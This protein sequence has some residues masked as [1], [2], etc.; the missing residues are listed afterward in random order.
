MNTLN[1]TYNAL[2]ENEEEINYK[3]YIKSLLQ[4]NVSNVL[5]SRLPRRRKP[6]NIHS[7]QLNKKLVNDHS[8]KADDFAAIF[9]VAKILRKDIMNLRRWKFNGSFNDFKIPKSLTT[10][11]KW[12]LV[13]PSPSFTNESAKKTTTKHNIKNIAQIIMRSTKST[14]QITQNT[15][16]PYKDTVKTPFAVGLGILVHKE[17]RNKKMIEYLSDLGLSISYKKVMKLE[18]GLGNMIVEKRNS[19]EGV[20]IPDNLTQNSCLHF[21]FDNIDFENY[22]ENGKCK[23]HGTTTVIFQ[24]KQNQ[25]EKSIEITL[26]NDLAFHDTTD[27]IHP[28]NKPVQSNEVFEKYND[29]SSIID[30]SDFTN[31]DRLWG[32]LQVVDVSQMCQLPAWN[33]LISLLTKTP[34]VTLCETLRLSPI[35]TTDWTGL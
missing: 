20:Y 9:E 1:L 24:K 7:D 12:V 5:F 18:N 19:N 11:L 10:L 25:K 28:C 26:T 33:A 13:G 27:L 6:E 31:Q 17:T 30:I 14:K 2:L 8:N 3:K 35:L 21:A 29:L 16:S 22:T 15:E 34:S 32:M 4:S 23:F